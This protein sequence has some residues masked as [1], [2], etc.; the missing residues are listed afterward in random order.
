MPNAKD[1]S[2]TSEYTKSVIIGPPGTGKS[3]FASSFPTPGFVFDFSCGILIYRGLDFDFE[4]YPTSAI[5]WPK[6]EKD[7]VEVKKKVEAGEYKTVVIDDVTAWEDLAME[8][9]MQ[10]D[11]KRS[12][13]G[14]PLWNVHFQM[15][16]NLMEGKIRRF[17][18]LKCNLIVICHMDV[19]QDQETGSIIAIEPLVVGKL[20]KTITGFF[21]EVYFATV[22]KEGQNIQWL[23]QTVPLGLKQARSRLSGKQR[24][25]PD[26]FP[27]DYTELMKH[28]TK[29]RQGEKNNGNR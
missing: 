3:V 2:I 5:G 9:A 20:S 25:L 21:D 16:R 6:F 18:E 23:M 17:L 27:N 4:Q 8:R 24:L 15:V 14:G 11:P 22:R 10:L 13:T 1:V 7:F 19:I 28:I 12:A 29:I 26:F